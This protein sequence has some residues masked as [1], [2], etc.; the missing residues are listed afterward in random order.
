V[1][2]S[3]SLLPLLF[4]ACCGT[5]GSAGAKSGQRI[6]AAPLLPPDMAV[7]DMAPCNTE[8]SVD[9]D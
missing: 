8:V 9:T 1:D 5:P 3:C 2:G 6:A 7:N 4:L